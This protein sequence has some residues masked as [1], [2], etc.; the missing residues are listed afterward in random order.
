MECY[1]L[2]KKYYSKKNIYKYA[3]QQLYYLKHLF[4]EN[5]ITILFYLT[6]LNTLK[7]SYFKH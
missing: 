6:F 2:S 5:S 4:F 7:N 3:L 1:Y